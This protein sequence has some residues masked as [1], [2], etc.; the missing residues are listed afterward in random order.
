[1]LAGPQR[2]GPAGATASMV[3]TDKF[4]FV[5][6]P[7]TGGTFVRQVLDSVARAEVTQ[8][9]LG[10]LRRAGLLPRRFH[11]LDTADYHDTCH[12]IPPEHRQKRIVSAIRDP[13]DFYVSFYHYGWWVAHPEDSYRDFDEVR[14][15]FPGFP[16]LSFAQFLD[17]ANGFFV[18]FDRIGD[19][20]RNH[21]MG[22]YS[23]QFLQYFFKSPT[24]AYRSIDSAYL[25][26]RAWRDDMFAVEFLR[27]STLN[28][29]LHQ[30]LATEGYP[31]RYIDGVL[32]KTPVRPQ[33][34]HTPRPGSSFKNYYTRETY[35]LVREKEQL[36]FGIFP[37]LGG[38]KSYEDWR[39][40][41]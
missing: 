8:G 5:H 34:H 23:T 3:I 14:R 1:M 41:G 31:R 29:D 25:A 33:E 6:Q 35:E 39:A 26:D 12:E 17:L 7:K 15:A 32:R 20:G 21:R 40:G 30:F 22:Y 2:T 13:F 9:P 4:V 18:D 16:D 10:R 11:Y 28:R 24:D 37:D 38:Q 27:T 36:L 19:P